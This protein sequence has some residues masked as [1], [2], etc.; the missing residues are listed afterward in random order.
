MT[1]GCV[2]VSDTVGLRKKEVKNTVEWCYVSADNS[3]VLVKRNWE[4]QCFGSVY[5]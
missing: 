4:R 3:S 2:H 5:T 1:T